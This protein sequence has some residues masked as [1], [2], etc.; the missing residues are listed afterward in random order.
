MRGFVLVGGFGGE[1]IHN[2]QTTALCLIN[3][4]LGLVH[5]MCSAVIC[6]KPRVLPQHTE[7]HY[8]LQT[9]AG[10]ISTYWQHHASTKFSPAN[11]HSTTVPCA[12]VWSNF[13][14]MMAPFLCV[15]LERVFRCVELERRK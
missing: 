4:I 5:T 8:V 1:R 9:H 3:Y 10:A 15:S 2:L 6:A 7:M 11:T 14:I 13:N 12:L